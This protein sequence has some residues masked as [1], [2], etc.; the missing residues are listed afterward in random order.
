MDANSEKFMLYHDG[1]YYID[2]ECDSAKKS[3]NHAIL[4]VGYNETLEI[5][6]WLIKSSFGTTWGEKGFGKIARNK[7]NHCGIASDFSLLI[8]HY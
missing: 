6:Y 2:A 8:F 7:N 1:V 5:D 3:I 4:V